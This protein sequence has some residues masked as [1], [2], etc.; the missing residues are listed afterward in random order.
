VVREISEESGWQVAAGPLLDCWQYHIGAGQDVLIVTYGCYVHSTGAPA[1][2]HEHQRAGLFLPG[3]VPALTMPV[4]YKRSITAWLAHP[5][6]TTSPTS[7]QSGE[8]RGP[9]P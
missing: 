8:P 1:V 9:R 4:G 7:S 5:V 3:Q 6:R 2:S